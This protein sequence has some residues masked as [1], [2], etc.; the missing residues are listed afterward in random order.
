MQEV[1]SN[2]TVYLIKKQHIFS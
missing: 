2:T 1:P